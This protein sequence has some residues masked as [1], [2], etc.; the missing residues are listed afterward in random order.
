MKK[1]VYNFLKSDLVDGFSIGF[2]ALLGSLIVL[3]ICICF[4]TFIHYTQEENENIRQDLDRIGKQV[5]HLLDMF[6]VNMILKSTSLRSLLITTGGF[7]KKSFDIFLAN[8][9]VMENEESLFLFS[10]YVNHTDRSNF[11][12][13]YFPIICW[14]VDIREF[15]VCPE[16][17]FYTP[18]IYYFDKY[19]IGKTNLYGFDP[20]FN[21]YQSVVNA[22]EL[23]EITVETTISTYTNEQFLVFFVPIFNETSNTFIGFSLGLLGIQSL[24]TK[25]KEELITDESI[26]VFVLTNQSDIIYEDPKFNFTKRHHIFDNDAFQERM[27]FSSVLKVRDKEMEIILVTTFEF[28]NEQKSFL[29]TIVSIVCA[30]IVCLSLF[31]LID[32]KKKRNMI[33]QIITE[34]NHLI[35]KILPEEISNKL[36]SGEDV[37]AERS[38][39]ASV[40]FLDIAGF[41]RFSS[42]HTP[43]QVIQV[44]IKIFNSLDL[45]CSKHNIEKIKTIG[46]AYM[47]TSGLSPNSGDIKENTE[48]MLDFAL[49]V[50]QNIPNEFS[51]HL[52]LRV[53]VGIH[54]GPVISG[55][56]SGY[57]KPHF[58]V[59]GDSVNI[60]SR[61]ESTGLPGQIH[62]SDRV[63]RLTKEN[64]DYY[65]EPDTIQVKG[66][67]KMKTWY[68]LGKLENNGFSLR[69]N[70]IQLRKEISEQND[71]VNPLKNSASSIKGSPHYHVVSPHYLDSD[72][73]MDKQKPKNNVLKP[74]LELNAKRAINEKM[75]LLDDD[76]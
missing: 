30:I 72:T 71:K 76:S 3:G 33:N 57:S 29:P 54:C 49:D 25:V 60:A 21:F 5:I 69:E 15:R 16:K 38:N 47:A 22:M 70:Y 17:N 42:I 34:K 24:V 11:E 23:N 61:M 35:H 65:E 68:L 52:G 59:W 18:A 31:Y 2:C 51:F 73:E 19:Q 74:I 58:D 8:T 62:V 7:N 66:K 10:K 4:F 26:N 53:R 50:L 39:N 36:E 63:Y 12:K 43:E 67:G 37:I 48:K 56:I 45:L 40:F 13:E 28:E 9:E 75:S 41:T 20:S 14:D 27:M 46:D 32:Q 44:L 6:V 1:T 55:V 64:Y